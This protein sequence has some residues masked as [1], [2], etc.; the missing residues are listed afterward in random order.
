MV[1]H[2]VAKEWPRIKRGAQRWRAWVVFLDESGISL[3]PVVRCTWAPRGQP[4]VLVHPF[5]WQRASM[6]AAVCAKVGGTRW[7]LQRFRNRLSDDSEGN[8]QRPVT[9]RARSTVRRKR[10]ATPGTTQSSKPNDIGAYGAVRSYLDGDDRFDDISRIAAGF[11]SLRA[12]R[13]HR[14]W[15]RAVPDPAGGPASSPDTAAN[16]VVRVGRA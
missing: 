5:H 6:C 10:C 16:A 8:P 15:R 9:D 1:D 7:N 11:A 13:P 2:W 4:P 14:R 3:T 12:C